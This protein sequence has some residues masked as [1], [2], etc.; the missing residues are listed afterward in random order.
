[1]CAKCS[2]CVCAY[3]VQHTRRR[4]HKPQRL[5]TCFRGCRRRC[6]LRVD[7]DNDDDKLYTQ[8]A[9][10]VC[11]LRVAAQWNATCVTFKHV[12]N[13]L[14]ELQFKESH[15]R[16]RTLDGRFALA[17]SEWQKHHR[18]ALLARIHLLRARAP[19]LRL[20]SLCTTYRF[21]L[22]THIKQPLPL[23]QQTQDW[24]GNQ[25]ACG[26]H[27]WCAS[28]RTKCVSQ[29]VIKHKR[30]RFA[31]R[32]LLS[33]CARARACA[34]DTTINYFYANRLLLCGTAAKSCVSFVCLCL[35]WC[36]HFRI[37][38]SLIAFYCYCYYRK[39]VLRY[40]GYTAIGLKKSFATQK[41]V[42]L[43]QKGW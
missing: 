3:F 17:L 31:L 43:I 23:P 18:R 40:N 15:A 8:R 19:S 1:M 30:I 34:L 20:L 24:W 37:A 14:R 12:H 7:N 25:H 16:A 10:A 6:V 39:N 35:W 28:S 2:V 21:C 32:R 36:R 11:G 4:G 27:T 29:P 9:H 38:H 5:A 26:V 13:R 22:V 33:G 42:L 41:F